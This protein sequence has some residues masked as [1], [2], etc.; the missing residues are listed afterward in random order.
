MLRNVK[1]IP[2]ERPRSAELSRP[3]GE[4]RLWQEALGRRVL[5]PSDFPS[6]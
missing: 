2:V 5:N 3:S 6:Y 1:E 4:K